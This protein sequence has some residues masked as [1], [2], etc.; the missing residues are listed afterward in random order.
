[1]NFKKPTR[2][3][4]IASLILVG[5]PALAGIFL[6]KS[7]IDFPANEAPRQDVMITNRGDEIAYVKVE[8]L[9]VKNPGTKQETRL[10]INDKEEINFIASPAKLAIPPKGRKQV[11]LTNLTDPGDEKVY[12][13]NFSPVLPPLQEDEEGMDVR[14]VVAYQVLALIHPSEP[15][16]NLIVKKDPI[17]IHFENKGNSYALISSVSQ[18][19][20]KGENCKE[21]LGAK[22]LY[23]GNILTL[24]TPYENTPVTYRLTNFKGSREETSK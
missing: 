4:L 22:R 3:A 16:E 19:D 21:D 12:R 20:T 13:I 7:I 17:S 6:D 10:P 8:V 18:C 11:R 14:V 9:E 1:M 5:H 23:P 2:V 15:V 24:P